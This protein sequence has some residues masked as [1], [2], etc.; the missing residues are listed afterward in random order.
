MG[1]FNDYKSPSR[2]GWKYTYKGEELLEPARKKY[3]DVRAR[4]MEARNT[5]ADLLRNP[6]IGPDDHKVVDNKKLAE[7]YGNE[8][9][10]CM[11]FCHEFTRNP[12][13]E[14]LLS[15]GDVTYF[16]LAQPPSDT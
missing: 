13:R 7:R 6:L 12:S 8:S 15:L 10:Q 2:E 1:L 14:Y 5:L 3:R 11:V 4:E 16:D 9:E